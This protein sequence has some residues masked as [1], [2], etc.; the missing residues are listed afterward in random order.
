MRDTK[1]HEYIQWKHDRI[2]N[3]VSRNC[4]YINEANIGIVALERSSGSI[5]MYKPKSPCCR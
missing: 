2:V 4:I 1:K 5:E 3:E